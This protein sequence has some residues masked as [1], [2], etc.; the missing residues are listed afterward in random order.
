MAEE[1]KPSFS[2]EHFL[3]KDNEPPPLAPDLL[4]LLVG[5]NPGLATSRSGHAYAHPSNLFWKLLHASGVTPR[6]CTARED[7][8]LPGLFALG[9][10]NLVARPSR[11]GA[12]LSR[13]E[14]DGGVAVLEDKVR[15]WRPE[16]VCLVGKGI[17]ESV[18]RV[19]GAKG[20][21]RMGGRG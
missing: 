15:V 12:E 11:S 17:W 21:S 2:L 18:R 7:G 13:G 10:T 14:M 5:L 1:T 4:V 3:Y 9:L 19:W 8:L 6:A 16:V 20:R